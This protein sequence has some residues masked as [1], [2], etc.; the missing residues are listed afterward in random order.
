MIVYFA[1]S[2]GEF[3]Y[4]LP[5]LKNTGGI[6]VTESNSLYNFVTSHYSFV[7]CH[8]DKM[9]NISTYHPDVVV[10]A[11]NYGWVP[12]NVKLVQVF[13]GLADKKSIYRKREFKDSHSLL[14]LICCFIESYLPKWL[15]KFSLVSDDLWKPFKHLELDKHIKNRYD[16]LCLV[17]KHMEEKFRELNLLT[18][19]NW[20]PVGFPRLDCEINNE[21]S[22]DEILNDLNLDPELKTVLYAPT[23]RGHQEMNLSSIADMGLEI[24]ESIDENMNFIFKPHPIV[25]EHNEFPEIIEQIEMHAKNQQNFVYPDAFT[26]IIPLLYVSDLL[27]TDFSTVAIEYLAFDRPI[28]FADHLGEVYIDPNLVEVWIREAGEIVRNPNEF[29]N[30]IWRCLESPSEKSEIRRRYCDYFFYTL[31]GK[32]SERATKAIIELE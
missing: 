10:L 11:G 15:S 19:T 16:L 3:N 28:I 8:L 22:R 9:R 27:I 12:K 6:L 1:T 30:A 4:M 25:K 17:G 26:D 23:W 18:D 32:A 20:K 2:S 5:I 31:D 24:C 21:L 29:T 13:H 7:K 14:F